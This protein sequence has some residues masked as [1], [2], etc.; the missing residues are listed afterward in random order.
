MKVEKYEILV[1]KEDAVRWVP[2]HGRLNLSTLGAKPVEGGK[3]F[4]GEPQYIAQAPYRGAVHQGKVCE[5]FKQEWMLP[6][7]R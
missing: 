3:E 5:S 1:G 2:V 7:S 6:P 4:S